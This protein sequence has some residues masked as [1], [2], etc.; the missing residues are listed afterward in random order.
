MSFENLVYLNS[1]K[2]YY[3]ENPVPVQ[4]RGYWEFQAVLSGQCFYVT[5]HSE[6]VISENCLWLSTPDNRHGW[7][8]QPG[9]RCEILTFHF[10]TV[11]ESIQSLMETQKNSQI[12]LNHQQRGKLLELYLET[13]QQ[14]KT[15]DA[16][17]DLLI[18][19]NL[20]ELSILV[21]KQSSGAPQPSMSQYYRRIAS[22][23]V[24]LFIDNMQNGWNV[25]K[26]A[27]AMEVS[28]VH[29]RRIFHSVYEQSPKEVFHSQRLMFARDQLLQSSA[30]ITEIALQCGFSTS[31]VFCRH[32]KDQYGTTPLRF[33]RKGCLTQ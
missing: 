32:F 7:D 1:G 31:S 25:E 26:V 15:P 24:G 19:K 21:L 29:L 20:L 16:T 13:C 12:A 4:S 3:A 10:Q 28:P 33:R 5:D 9:Q 23:A 14:V 11:P 30:S 22:Q 18:E 8:G 2:R 17:S 6:P 27:H